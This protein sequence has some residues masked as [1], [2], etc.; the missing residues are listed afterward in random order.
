MNIGS[1]S[2]FV[3]FF[4]LTTI[5]AHA[6]SCQ[7]EKVIGANVQPGAY[8]VNVTRESDDLYKVSTQDIYIKTLYCYEYSYSQDAI[9]EI[10]SPQ[11]YS[12]GE[13]HFLSW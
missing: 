5:P 6:G 10:E 9:L 3:L 13:I 2:A 12:I 1:L 8:K 7:V 11:G 4:C